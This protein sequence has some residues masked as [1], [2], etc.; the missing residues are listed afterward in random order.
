L[1]GSIIR[2]CSVENR[3]VSGCYIMADFHAV[4]GTRLAHCRLAT[5]PLSRPGRTK[6]AS[7]TVVSSVLRNTETINRFWTLLKTYIPLEDTSGIS[8]TL[9]T[10][11]F[12]TA[13]HDRRILHLYLC[14]VFP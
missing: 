9:H 14:L 3:H 13:I 12:V 4:I 1:R 10:T 7:L 11:Q 5:L 2:R 8:E 6:S